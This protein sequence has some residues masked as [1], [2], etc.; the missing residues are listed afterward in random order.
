MQLHSPHHAGAHAPRKSSKG[1][2]AAIDKETSRH[3]KSLS[4][5]IV[6]PGAAHLRRRPRSCDLSIVV[7]G[8]PHPNKE[9]VLIAVLDGAAQSVSRLASA[10]EDY[11]PNRA[12]ST[13]RITIMAANQVDSSISRSRVIA[14]PSG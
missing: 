10:V 13:I 4:A 3:R 12:A 9:R 2:A 7:V 11:H 1:R 5:S 6:R 14:S 8:A